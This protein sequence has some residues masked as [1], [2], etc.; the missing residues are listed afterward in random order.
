MSARVLYFSPVRWGSFAQRPHHMARYLVER[1]GAALTWVEPYPTR[2]PRWADRGRIRAKPVEAEVPWTARVTVIDVPALPIEP[3]TGG[4]WLNRQFVWRRVC[5]ALASAAGGDGD[6]TI[7]VGKPSALAL[8]ALRAL[9]HRTSF[10]DAMDDFPAFYD[11]W[12]RAAA[13]RVE[14]EIAA[15][16]NR[17]LVCS[18]IVAAKFE[19]VVPHLLPNGFDPRSLAPLSARRAAPPVLG[20]VGTMG[21]WFDWPLIERL[22]HELSVM[23]VVLVGPM[24]SNGRPRLPA[25]VEWLGEYPHTR[26]MDAM[27]TFSIG[28]VPFKDSRVARAMDP[29]KLYEY[30]ALGLPVVASNVGAAGAWREADGVFLLR[31]GAPLRAVVERAL[32]YTAGPETLNRVREEST[33]DRRFDDANIGSLLIRS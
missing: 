32:A 20:F 1:C 30:R 17:V 4:A 23:R 12:S 9:P 22:A 3:L 5:A 13:A 31:D 26:A 21:A 10:Y 25:N 18:P 19:A 14:A 33:W 16:V 27:R 11:G 29:I 28:L 6:G 2:L 15:V 8:W 24:A 7:A